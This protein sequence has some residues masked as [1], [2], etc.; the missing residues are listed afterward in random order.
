MK[1]LLF[2][3]AT[4]VTAPPVGTR[5]QEEPA[6]GPY[7]Q[8]DDRRADLERERSLDS[9]YRREDLPADL[10][11]GTPGVRPGGDLLVPVIDLVLRPSSILD[12]RPRKIVPWLPDRET[13]EFIRE[14]R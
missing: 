2:A 1:L 12:F 3:V 5:V 9:V 4:A 11:Y 14:R 13:S 8:R 7:V 10:W 6:F